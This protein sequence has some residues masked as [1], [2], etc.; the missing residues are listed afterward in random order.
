MNEKYK[1]LISNSVIFTVGNFGSKLLVF[2]MVPF[3]T[4]Y[5]S[6]ADYGI[7]DVITTTATLIMPLLIFNIYDAVL[8]FAMDRNYT[9]E[10]ILSNSIFIFAISVAISIILI[11]I[12]YILRFEQF[13]SIFFLIIIVLVQGLQSILSQYVRGNGL[14]KLY[15]ING[16]ILAIVLSL[17]NILFIAVFDLKV[18]GYLLS[19]ILS[20]LIAIGHLFFRG[21][22]YGLISHSNIDTRILK[23]ML[24]YSLPLIPNSISWWLM[25]ASNKYFVLFFLGSRANGLLAVASKIPGLISLVNNIFFQAWQM[26]AIEEY[27]S[28]DKGLFYTKIF[29]YLSKLMFISVSILLFLLQPIMKIM[30]ESFYEAWKIIPFLL[31]SVLYS[32]FSGFLGTNYIAAKKTK[33]I[34]TTTLVGT[35]I[36][37]L[38]N[39][40]IIPT[41]GINYVGLGNMASFIVIF[42]IRYIDTKKFVDMKIHWISFFL[43]QFLILTEILIL[44]T[45][46]NIKLQMSINFTILVLTCYLNRGIFLDI[47]KYFT[48]QR[49]K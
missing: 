17:L 28:E 49:S 44:Y 46:S 19:I 9:K 27:E 25:N 21:K 38:I 6:T 20:N 39:L 36:S 40:I 42:A 26:S 23:K 8:R 12:L 47:N 15:A 16:I 24:V 14:V 34:F 22:I 13:K 10:V 2:I 41:Y 29:S 32:S 45:I 37:L 3:Y 31:I 43:N 5:L 33:G 30:Q 35:V 48:K 4:Y 7:V 1:K 11:S 18:T